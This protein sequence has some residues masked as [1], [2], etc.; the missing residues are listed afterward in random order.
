MDELLKTLALRPEPWTTGEIIINTAAAFLLGIFVTW[1]YRSTHRQ[2]TI[3]FSFVN[4]MVLLA[5]IMTVVMM[6]IGDN[7]ARA[8]GLAGAMSIIRFRTVVKDTRDTAFVFFALGVGMGTGTGNLRLAV[9]GTLLI[10]FFIF[11]LHW[12]RHGAIARNEY[13]LSMHILP[14]MSEEERKVYLP[15]FEQYLDQ[16]RLLNVQSSRMGDAL[17]LTFHVVLKNPKLTEK[18]VGDLSG[19]EGLHR[20]SLAYGE[21]AEG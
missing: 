8:F 19:L 13:M 17:K 21:T 11:V 5:M 15:V 12:T 18:L 4:T 16:H 20:V 9:L 6:V 14:T 10:G 2:L 1:V 3:S 7:I